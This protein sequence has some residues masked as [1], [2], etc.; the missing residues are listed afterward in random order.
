MTTTA[1]VAAVLRPQRYI[2][3]GWR[4]KP[5]EQLSGIVPTYR[6]V[7]VDVGRVSAILV[8]QACERRVSGEA[9]PRSTLR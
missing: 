1:A 2:P 3:S 9:G 6:D 8:R 5:M 7:V 4:S